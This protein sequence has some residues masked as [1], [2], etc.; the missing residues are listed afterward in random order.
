[1]EKIIQI[2]SNGVPGTAMGPWK[3]DLPTDEIKKLAAFVSSLS[4]MN[5]DA[6]QAGTAHQNAMPI[7]YNTYTAAG[8][9]AVG[10]SAAAG[11]SIF[12]D[13]TQG[14]SCAACHRFQ[15]MGGRVGPDL[16]DLSSKSPDAILDSII[17]PRASADLAYA[18]VVLTIRSGQRYVGLKRDENRDEIRLYDTSS[19]PPVLRTF[20]RRDV[21]DIEPLNV[22]TMRADYGTKYSKQELLDLVTFLKVGGP[23][24]RLMFPHVPLQ[25]H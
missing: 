22:P 5:G 3:D 8:A 18:T 15:G 2:I 7:F 9:A 21:V 23:N 16:T 17:H 6:P 11:R 12:F 25:Q 20:I 13:D 19:M 10:G 14:G 24:P 4:A 1:M